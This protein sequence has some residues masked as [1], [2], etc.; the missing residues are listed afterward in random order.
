MGAVCRDGYCGQYFCYLI[1]SVCRMVDCGQSCTLTR[2][3][4]VI[5]KRIT[6]QL[7]IKRFIKNFMFPKIRAKIA[8][9]MGTLGLD[10]FLRL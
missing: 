8:S 7:E 6:V 2:T 10:S 9:K 1:A 3:K 4:S 5:A